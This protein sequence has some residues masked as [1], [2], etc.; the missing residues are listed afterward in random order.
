M[1]RDV[2]QRV[3]QKYGGRC[4]DCG[5]DQYLE[6]DHIVPLARGGSDSDSNVQLLCR[7]CDQ[8]KSDPI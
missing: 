8:K 2:R 4:A 5:S 3:W 1:P 6:F 7:G